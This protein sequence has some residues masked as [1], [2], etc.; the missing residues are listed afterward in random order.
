M[1]EVLP[2]TV[3][4]LGWADALGETYESGYEYGKELMGGVMRAYGPR[5]SRHI[6]ILQR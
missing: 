6:L 1:A 3:T 4:M 5:F 2:K